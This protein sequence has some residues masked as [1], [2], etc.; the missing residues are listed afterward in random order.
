MATLSGRVKA[1][2]RSAAT[3]HF[4]TFKLG[5]WRRLLGDSLPMAKVSAA[6]VD[7]AIETRRSEGTSENTIHKELGALRV[8]LK[9]AKRAG[10]WL[11]DPATVLPVGHAP[12]YEPRTRWLSSVDLQR[13]LAKLPPNRAAMVAFVVATGARWSEAERVEP[14][15]LDVREGFVRIR[16][17]KTKASDRTVPIVH[18]D[19]ITLLDYALKHAHG[20]AWA[21]ENKQ[22]YTRLF[23]PWPSP[24]HAL[25]RACVAAK[26]AHT[27]FNDLR[28]TFATWLRNAG[29]TPDLIAPA[30]GHT[31][32]AMVQRIY[33]RL[34]PIDLGRLISAAIVPSTHPAESAADVQQTE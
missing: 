4:Y 30:M 3:V 24:N 28:R 16:G 22:P 5:H 34:A 15:D 23:A 8:L 18:P 29:A 31:T 14:T 9:T 21:S 19:A 26:I 33:A 10:V 2:K 25:A 32:T 12:E 11:G 6:L 1:G 20:K 17:T 13:L 7:K 27:S